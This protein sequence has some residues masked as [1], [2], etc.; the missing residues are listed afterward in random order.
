MGL[1]P[2]RC[3]AAT[4][5][6]AQRMAAFWRRPARGRARAEVV[7]RLEDRVLDVLGQPVLRALLLLLLEEV[8]LDLGR[9]RLEAAQLLVARERLAID[10][11]DFRF[12]WV[13]E[14]PLMHFDEEAGRYVASHHPFT[15]PVPEDS[16]LLKTDP[17]QVRGQHYDLVLNGVELGGGSIRIHQPE[18]AYPTIPRSF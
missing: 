12:L 11:K 2:A 16:E 5:V 17:K 9:V 7:A 8:P 3:A 13:I 10:P 18:L 6:L 15:A 4:R 14:F 1:Q